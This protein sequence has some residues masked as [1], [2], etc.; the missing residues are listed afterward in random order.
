[1]NTVGDWVVC[2]SRRGQIEEGEDHSVAWLALRLVLWAL[3]GM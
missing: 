3:D 1:V 2:Q